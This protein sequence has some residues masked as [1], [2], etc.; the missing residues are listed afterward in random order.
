MKRLV[1]LTILALFFLTLTVYSP[2]VQGQTSDSPEEN[3]V[4]YAPVSNDVIGLTP[5][6][7][8]KLE[9]LRKARQGERKAH[10]EKMQRLRQEM[11]ELMQDPQANE[12]DIL[13]L[14]EQMS[15][16]RAERFR[17]SLR[18]RTEFRKILTPEQLQKL[19]RFKARIGERRNVLGGRFL[20]PRA[21]AGPPRF[22]RQGRMSR[23]WGRGGRFGARPLRHWWRRWRW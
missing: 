10:F 20:G 7:K 14:Y 4:D 5:E 8:A 22:P 11:R 9:E 21:M 15:S 3:A 16:L 17:N 18:D 2:L 13:N 1:E 19:D 6:Q 23:F 12:K